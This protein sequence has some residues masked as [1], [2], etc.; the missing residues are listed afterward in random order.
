VVHAPFA[1]LLRP[2]DAHEKQG[3]SASGCRAAALPKLHAV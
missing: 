1:I 3:G 2:R